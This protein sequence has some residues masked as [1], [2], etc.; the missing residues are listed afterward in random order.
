MSEEE[1]K[2]LRK[3]QSDKLNAKTI[4]EE[5]S[6]IWHLACR[7]QTIHTCREILGTHTNLDGLLLHIKDV[8]PEDV[9]QELQELEIDI[10]DVKVQ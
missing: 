10:A 1:I 2:I 5:L 3:Y 8:R 4:E 9:K 6:L 7:L